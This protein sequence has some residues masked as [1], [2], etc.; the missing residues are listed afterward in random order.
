M[1]IPVGAFNHDQWIADRNEALRSLDINKVRDYAAKY[2][3]QM[4]HDDANCELAMHKARTA[5]L[6]LSEAE[7]KLSRDWCEA[8]GYSHW[9][10]EA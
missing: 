8:R 2:G 6:A 3:S 9:G 4:P 7:R 10:D 5:C 1:A